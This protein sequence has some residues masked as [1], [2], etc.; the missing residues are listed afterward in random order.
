MMLG[1]ISGSV[2]T[3]DFSFKAE[4]KV[5][6]LQYVAVKDMDGKWTLSYIDSITNYMNSTVAKAKVIGHRD[7]R[8][9]LKSLEIPFEPETPVYTADDDLIKATLGLK[10]DGLYLGIMEGYNIPI[11]LP[12]KHM[13]T[14]HVAILAKTGTG[15]SY[16][17]GVVLE[18]L[19]E[20]GIPVVVIDPHG[21]YRTLLEE[22]KKESE[23]SQMRRFGI[24]PK[25]YKDKVQIF[26]AGSQNP[27]RLNP[28]LT[29]DE[30]IE[31]LPAKISPGQEGQLYAAVKNL[32]GKDYA[33]KDI[34]SELKSMEG[35]VKRNLISLLEFIDGTKLFSAN[36]TKP[37]DLVKEGK[38]T[39]IDLNEASPDIQ[40]I[41][42]FKLA[43]ELFAARKFGKIPEFF[44]VL[45]E[46][47][48]FCPERG[49]GEVASSKILRTIASEGRKFGMG[50]CIIS[51]RPAKVDK[52][53]L[54]QC[55]TQIILKVT[56]PNDI[57]AI[58]N[59]VE[60]VE[61]GTREEIRDLPIGIAMVVG[62]TE[63]P[64][65]VDVRIRK[66]QHGGE[67]V[68]K[69]AE[70][71]GDSGAAEDKTAVASYQ[72]TLQILAPRFLEEDVL[73]VFKGVDDIRFINYPLWKA[74]GV[75]RGQ[76]VEFYVDGLSGE[77]VFER[78]GAIACSSGVRSIL[79]LPDAQR[80]IVLYLTK[81]KNATIEN[82]S[83]SQKMLLS[84]ARANLKQLLEKKI[85]AQDEDGVYRII[86]DVNLP[87]DLANAKIDRK[88]IEKEKEGDVLNFTISTDFVK[89]LADIWDVRVQEIKPLYFPYWLIVHGKRKYL[90]NALNNRLEIDRS[91]ALKGTI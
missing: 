10:D 12:P 73:R 26:D 69:S 11:F 77:V 56:N 15:K 34:I 52:N 59:S 25:S 6:K 18:E 61:L 46:A 54:S 23:V 68:A 88:T 75:R 43:R 84:D 20:K 35:N 49:L 82:I 9:F 1:R 22:N 41:V 80:G 40:Q 91:K 28:K 31:M 2:T 8:G 21:E 53:V 62:I 76:D 50:L 5:K 24:Q 30:I 45:E 86:A 27:I 3:K 14:K 78:D 51:Q 29:A 71:P 81:N 42:V 57:N 19:A 89:R 55:S 47:H 17:T 37:G 85:V 66:S 67:A 72:G 48:N 7:S 87:H 44:F 33:L 70:M 58:M 16:T 60:G 39:I 32:E 4:A 90:V 63:Q 65:I 38:V 83:G 74:G 64:L 79:E 36:P 13:I